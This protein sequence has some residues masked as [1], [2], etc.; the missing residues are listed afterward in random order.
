M[1]RRELVRALEAAG[2]RSTGGT[3]HEKFVKGSVRVMVPRH[4]DVK[5]STARAILRDAGLR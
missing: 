1:Q 5:E 2:F 4:K 3:K